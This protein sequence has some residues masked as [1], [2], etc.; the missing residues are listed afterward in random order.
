M[1]TWS[2]QRDISSRDGSFVPEILCVANVN[3]DKIN[4]WIDI[5][6]KIV[7]ILD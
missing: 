3:H 5:F 7:E 4:F 2:G 6:G 1:L